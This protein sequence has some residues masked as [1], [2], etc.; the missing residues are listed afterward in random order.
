MR[1]VLFIVC[2]VFSLSSLAY[3][4]E[5][6]DANAADVHCL[7]RAI[8][9]ANIIIKSGKLSNNPAVI[10]A[11]MTTPIYFIGRIDAR[12]PNFDLPQNFAKEI[13]KMKKM[14]AEDSRAEAK[15]CGDMLKAKGEELK[16]VARILRQQPEK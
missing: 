2:F 13:D 12:T 16:E 9:V 6:E 10:G 4:N 15:R 3:A 7:L 11:V 14:T 8:S 1:P 5:I